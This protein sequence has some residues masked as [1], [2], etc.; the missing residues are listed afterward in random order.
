MSSGPTSGAHGTHGKC[1]LDAERRE[2]QVLARLGAG[3]LVVEAG[4]EY[5]A[6][7]CCP[8]PRCGSPCSDL[9]YGLNLGI[10]RIMNSSKRGTVKAMSP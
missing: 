1:E 5:A 7:G 3:Q 10:A 2:E 8:C 9:D 6:N 4:G